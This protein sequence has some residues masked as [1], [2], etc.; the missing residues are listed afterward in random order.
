MVDLQPL[1]R[2]TE[3]IAERRDAQAG[4]ALIVRVSPKVDPQVPSIAAS[5]ALQ[6]P[7]LINLGA[8]ILETTTVASERPHAQHGPAVGCKA[9]CT[10]KQHN[11]GLS[12]LFLYC[13][14][15]LK[16]E[17]VGVAPYAIDSLHLGPTH[18]SRH[19]GKPRTAHLVRFTQFQLEWK[20]RAIGAR[21]AC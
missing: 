10:V 19:I 12:E 20:E 16:P 4:A 13:T 2:V 7:N 1:A 21:L 3:N 9:V 6:H 11:C 18:A 8:A 14:I 5:I 15:G 17:F